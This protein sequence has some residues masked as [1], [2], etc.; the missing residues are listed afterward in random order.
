MIVAI[1]QARMGSTRLPGK[2][3]K[4]V[5]G[6]PLLSYQIERMQRSS[7]LDR[8]VIATSTLPQDDAI[9][10]F[11]QGEGVECFRGSENDVLSRYYDCAVKYKAETIVRITGD[12]P[13]ID[14]DIIDHSIEAFRSSS[15]DYM[16]NTVPVETSHF[17][18]G[19]DVEVFSFAALERAYRE[20]E[21]SH[22]REHVTFYFWRED[23]GFKVGQLQQR[24]DWSGYRLTVDYPEDL[25]VVKYV[26]TELQKHSQ[27]GTLAEIVSILVRNKEVRQLNANHFLGEGWSK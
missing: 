19:S 4:E 8:L 20:C 1:V 16:V 5:E 13:L 10:G 12:C 23:N 6:R 9:F 7:L 27:R 11:C 24:E 18:D 21:G 15:C 14:P 2:V 26:L 3:L 25:E 22:Y 17:P